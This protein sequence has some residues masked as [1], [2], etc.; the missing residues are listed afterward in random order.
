VAQIEVMHNK[1][2]RLS[3]T[4]AALVAA[5]LSAL[6]GSYAKFYGSPDVGIPTSSMQLNAPHEI[7]LLHL[8]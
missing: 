6:F 8:R 7:T 3:L 2:R 5:A 1:A 4:G